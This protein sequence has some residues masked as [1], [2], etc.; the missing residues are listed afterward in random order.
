[1]QQSYGSPA[2]R[3][4]SKASGVEP[5]KVPAPSGPVTMGKAPAP[6]VTGH[7]PGSPIQGFD[8]GLISGKV[9]A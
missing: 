2:S 8:G 5:G 3:N 6:G 9:G 4:T 7:K 1:M